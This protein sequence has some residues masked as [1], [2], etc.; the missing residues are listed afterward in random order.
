[1]LD[2]MTPLSFQPPVFQT[3][4]VE[5]I[6]QAKK[7][8]ERLCQH[9]HYFICQYSHP[10]SGRWFSFSTEV[11]FERSQAMFRGIVYSYGQGR[12]RYATPS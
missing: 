5:S 12:P 8:A 7:L 11:D 2:P 1:M 9:G 6:A 10:H 3:I 4:H